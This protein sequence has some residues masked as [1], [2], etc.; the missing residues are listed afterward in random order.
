MDLQAR[1]QAG[2]DASLTLK[3]DKAKATRTASILVHHERGID[4]TAK[5]GKVLAELVVGGFLA[6]AADK[7][8]GR[9]FLLIAGDG[10]FGVDLD[11]GGGG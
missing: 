1:S 7:D 8:L 3:R 4:D 9:L 11:G 2:I 5:L 10:A 6:D